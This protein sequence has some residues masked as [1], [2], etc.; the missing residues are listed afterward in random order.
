MKVKD[1]NRIGNLLL[2]LPKT[3]QFGIDVDSNEWIKM[4]VAVISCSDAEICISTSV[5]WNCRS[6]AS[7]IFK[8]SGNDVTIT[9]RLKNIPNNW[10]KTNILWDKFN[11]AMVK[12]ETE[13]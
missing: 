9:E 11:T 2:L 3:L 13:N 7:A 8:T 4:S 6:G 12:F 10:Y 1:N 5:H